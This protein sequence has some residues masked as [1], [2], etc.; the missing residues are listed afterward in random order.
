MH[1]GIV[2]AP[3]VL[4][5]IFGLENVNGVCCVLLVPPNSTRTIVRVFGLSRQYYQHGFDSAVGAL[6]CSCSVAKRRHDLL[7]RAH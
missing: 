7:V 4:I 2:Q 6:C 3:A 5:L 1:V